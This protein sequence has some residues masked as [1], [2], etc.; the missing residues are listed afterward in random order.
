MRASEHGAAGG[1]RRTEPQGMV[2]APRRPGTPRFQK[3]SR[4]AS[5]C[6]NFPELICGSMMLGAQALSIFSAISTGAFP[7][8]RS[9]DTEVGV[10]GCFPHHS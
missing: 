1:E 3:A 10:K 2:V 5:S 4:K 8:G 9:D 7:L 6:I